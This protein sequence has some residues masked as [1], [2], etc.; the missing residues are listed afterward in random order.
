MNRIILY[1]ILLGIFSACS[2]KTEEKELASPNEN[3]K[4]EKKVERT[5]IKQNEA[6]VVTKLYL[7]PLGRF[8]QGEAEKLK[9]ELDQHLG[10]CLRWK[11]ECIVLPTMPLNDNLLNSAKTR[12][13]A[14]K[15]LNALSPKANKNTI[16]VG[17]AHDDISTT[18]RGHEDWGI[19][20]LSRM[21]ANVCVISTFRVKN[22]ADFWKLATHELTHA[23]YDY[24][25]CPKNDPKCIIQNANGHPNYRQK[26]GEL[27]E[28]CQKMIFG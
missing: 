23:L 1:I 15:I 27:C 21:K 5:A 10:T 26:N 4:A 20:G 13:R 28:Y 25:H 24:N 22:K 12:Y 7:Q 2:V 11:V 6:N 17:M 3:S 8:S 16:V 18:L 14:E 19:Q 9:S